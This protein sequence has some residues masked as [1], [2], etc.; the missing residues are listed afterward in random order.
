M[1]GFKP[2]VKM[3]CGGSVKGYNSGGM[4]SGS[5]GKPKMP[6]SLQAAPAAAMAAPKMAPKGPMAPGKAGAMMAAKGPAQPAMPKKRAGLAAGAGK[7]SMFKDGGHVDVKE[8]KA[9]VKT[10]VK[11][12]CLKSDKKMTK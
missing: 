7:V 2:C 1:K 12:S 5:M 9:L 11:P 6:K 8:D 10:M 3:A 4:A